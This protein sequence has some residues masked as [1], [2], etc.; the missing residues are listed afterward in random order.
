MTQKLC[1]KIE[2]VLFG[3]D[4]IRGVANIHPMTPEIAMQVG[5]AI[6]YRVKNNKNPKIVIG[7]DTRLSGYMIET[8][9][10][11]GIVSMGVDVYLV[12]PLP[13]PAIALL[14][15][16][17]NC[18]AGI[19]ITASHNPAEDNGIKIFDKDGFKLS[20]DEEQKIEELILSEKT[21][22]QKIKDII[23]NKIG[24]A[25]RLD[26]A[27][28]R[29]I[30]FAKST[31]G[32]FNLT[33]LKIVLDC[34][35][36]AAYY[37]APRVFSELGAEVIIINDKPDGL[38]INKECGATFPKIIG[39]LVKKNKADIGIS[40]DGDADRVIIAD[41]N[42]EIV[43][44]DYILS[45]CA[46]ELVK[47]NKLKNNTLVLTDYSNLGVD[48]HLKK[49][50]IEVIRTDNGDRY[51]IEEMKKNN[52]NLG[53][54]N[55]GHIIFSDY[56]TTG[57][58]IISALQFIKLIKEKNI[59]VSES[60]QYIKK[61]PQIIKNIDVK[62]KKPLEDLKGLQE[63]LKEKKLILK[64]EGRI[65]IRYSG[66]QNMC[67]ILVE[68]ENENIIKEIVEELSNEIKKEVGI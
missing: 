46:V 7:K 5:K 65:L 49:H 44:G 35:N 57:D 21:C 3:T 17:L 10:T 24:K 38:N 19:V 4:G 50:N 1:E 14:T 61:Y 37:V 20:D 6:A 16:S 40:L 41:E 36:G 22:I 8:A 51:V 66:T 59:K 58:G 39:E 28:G 23:G 30:E 42:G 56:T 60:R 55:S 45:F 67:R 32:D 31:I 2:R 12:G 48:E 54:E 26:D 13:T 34:A 52:Y 64:N 25:Y 27:K 11:S 62:E 47:K 15:K 63:K 43:D 29:Y 33:G 68:G 18:H 9:L 53:G